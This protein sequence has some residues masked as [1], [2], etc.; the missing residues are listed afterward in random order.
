[1]GDELSAL[2]TLFCVKTSLGVCVAFGPKPKIC[3]PS[4]PM[5][6]K[7]FL[8]NVQVIFFFLQSCLSHMC[9]YIYTST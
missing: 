5:S 1:M 7:L 2:V 4:T 6:L 9:M 3:S 8:H